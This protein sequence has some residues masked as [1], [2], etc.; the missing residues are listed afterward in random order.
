VT[1]F[2]WSLIVWGCWAALFV[3]L[4]F[5]AVFDKTSWNTLSWTAWQLQAR[6]GLFSIAFA[7]GLFVLL[8]HI[9]LPGRWPRRGVGYPKRDEPEGRN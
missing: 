2:H 1:A 9:L 6:S 7:G 3:V 8:L 4:E 5:L